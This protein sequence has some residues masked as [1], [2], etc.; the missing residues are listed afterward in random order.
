MESFN[1]QLLCYFPK[2]IHF[3]TKV[4][5]MRMSLALLNWVSVL[6]SFTS[7]ITRRLLQ[8]EN[9]HRPHT[10]ESAVTDLRRPDRHSDVKVL[11]K[12][13]YNFVELLWAIYIAHNSVD[14]R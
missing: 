10:S 1:H 3:S 5:D 8:N 11:V 12:K 9:V 13:T 14:S 7:H 2:R 6:S 4:F